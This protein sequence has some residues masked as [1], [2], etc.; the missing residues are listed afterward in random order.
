[1]FKFIP[2]ALFIISMSAHAQITHQL[3]SLKEEACHPVPPEYQTA[4]GD[5]QSFC[6]T[7]DGLAVSFVIL[8]EGTYLHLRDSAKDINY[9]LGADDASVFGGSGYVQDTAVDIT[10]DKG[11]AVGLVYRG[12]GNSGRSR[13]IAVRLNTNQEANMAVESAKCN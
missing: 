9:E 11:K 13:L 8:G 2:I 12:N 5:E 4:R 1:M 6:G 10:L 7:V 3:V